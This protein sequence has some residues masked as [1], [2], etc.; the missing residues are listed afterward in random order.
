RAGDGPAAPTPAAGSRPRRRRRAKTIGWGPDAAV[1][2]VPA[3]SAG[4][5]IRAARRRARLCARLAVR[6][7]AALP[8]RVGAPLAAR[9]RGARGR[10]RPRR[11]RAEPAPRRGAGGGDGDA[12]AVRA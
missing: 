12:R 9:R 2:L 1:V 11:A 7:A 10:A 5:R 4:G 8:P 6:V 3:G